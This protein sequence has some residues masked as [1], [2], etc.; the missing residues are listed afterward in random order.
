[1]RT[2]ILLLLSCALAAQ[3]PTLMNAYL[4]KALRSEPAKD[5]AILVK[6]NPVQVRQFTESHQGLFKYNCGDICSIILSGYHISLLSKTG[7]VSRMEYY[8]RPV[9]PLDDSSIVKNNLLKIHTG[10]SPLPQAYDG[11]GVTFGL[12]DTGIEWRHPDFKD[13]LTGK[14]RIKWLW[15]QNK[16][17]APNTPQPYNYGQ[18]WDA[19][20]IDSGNCTHDDIYA[21][22]HGTK[23]AGIAA[24]NGST[25]WVYKGHAPKADIICVG[26][27]FSMPGPVV[28]DAINYLVT[29]ANALGQPL[30]LNLSIGDYYGSH[31]G[32]DLQAQAIDA[33]FANV[34]G[35]CAVAAAGNAGNSSWHLGYTLGADTSLTFMQNTAGAQLSWVAYADTNNFKQAYF[36]VGVHDD[37]GTYRYVGNAGWKNILNI[38]GTTVTDT[39]KNSSGQRIGYIETTAGV[40]A[41]TYELLFNIVA[42]TVGYFWTMETTGQGNFDAWNFDFVNVNLPSPST[43]PRIVYYKMPDSL[44]TICTSFQ[45]SEEVIAVADYTSRQGHMSCQQSYWQ[46]PGPYDTLVSYSS[47]GPTRDN[48]MKPDIAATGD[49]ILTACHLGLCQYMAINFPTTNQIIAED[50]MHITFSGTSSAAPSVAGF[51][52]LYLQKNPTA[53]SSQIRNAITSC[54]RQDYYTGPN[55]PNYSWGY[56]KLDGYNAMICSSAIAGHGASYT[57]RAYPNPAQDRLNFSLSD[58]GGG[59]TVTVYSVLGAQIGSW[60][61][62]Q[63]NPALFV[64]NMPQGLYLYRILHEG[65]VV[66]EGK[67]IKE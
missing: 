23:V 38:L 15:D 29:K 65:T 8:E 20:Q 12:V 59:V 37:G 43:L 44:Q 34:P 25:N 41:G 48:R 56:G 26:L 3:N 42:D 33:L 51:V 24:S 5:Y 60:P 6:G 53:T 61:L 58:L 19:A 9:K 39:I 17:V 36:T 52:A 54:A 16:A 40:Q 50:T 14:T 31:D 35:R 30:V 4:V 67:F 27:N 46:M 21:V 47:R 62:D 66:G 22:G 1:M 2:I 64:G 10:Q 13:S 45:C 55:L 63:K 32:K 49:N 7:L 57:I 11:S 28:L 18:E